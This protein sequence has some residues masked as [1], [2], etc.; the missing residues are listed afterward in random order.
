[1][2]Q[3]NAC[4]ILNFIKT[5]LYIYGGRE[6]NPVMPLKLIYTSCH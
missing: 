1:M 4:D 5:D 2:Y 6:I 3:I